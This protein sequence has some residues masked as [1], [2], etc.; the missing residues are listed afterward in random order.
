MT[1]IFAHS[2]TD[3]SQSTNNQGL[4]WISSVITCRIH[5][6]NELSTLVSIIETKRS[7]SVCTEVVNKLSISEPKDIRVLDSFR[8]DSLV[9]E[10]N[11]N[12]QEKKTKQG[13]QKKG[14][15][16]KETNKDGPHIIEFPYQGIGT[17][18]SWEKFVQRTRAKN[19]RRY[20]C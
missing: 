1:V 10:E 6:Q 5:Y 3:S 11:D 16:K 12:N 4:L 7:L 17:R 2:L 20:T 18:S 15:R 8:K 19:Q 13:H 14:K 9:K